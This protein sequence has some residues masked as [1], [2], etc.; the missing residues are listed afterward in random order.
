MLSFQGARCSPITCEISLLGRDRVSCRLSPPDRP[1]VQT[2]NTAHHITEHRR[3][4]VVAIVLFPID[5]PVPL[6]RYVHDT[7]L[8]LPIPNLCLE[9]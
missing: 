5:F 4:D 8:N 3:N 2:D 9:F 7:L 6:R 1:V